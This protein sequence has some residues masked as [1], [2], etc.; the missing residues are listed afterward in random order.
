MTE[1]SKIYI[2]ALTCCLGSVYAAYLKQS[3]PVWMDTL[4]S[5][6]VVTHPS[7]R[8]TLA[9]CEPYGRLRVVTTEVF[10]AHN[11]AFNKGAAL[12]QAYAA[13]D[14]TDGVLHFDSDIMPPKNWREIAERE[15]AHGSIHGAVRTEEAGKKIE[16]LGDWP[17]G[18]FQLWHAHDVATHF[19][20]I[21][22]VWHQS[23]GGYDLEFLEKWPT[24]LRR[25][26]SF[27]VVHFGEVRRNWFGVGL[28]PEQQEESFKKMDHVHKIGLRKARLL[29]RV[30]T[31]RLRV[32]PF[33]LRFAIRPDP[34]RPERI[35]ELIRACQT[36]DPFLVEA[37]VGP[38]VGKAEVISASV[39]PHQ[40]RDRVLAAYQARHGSI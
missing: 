36:R 29:T 13:M 19:W 21:M 40:L 20:P 34:Q 5:L 6:T 39:E 2:D 23:A 10:K 30:P 11:A 1:G 9:V 18:Y 15:F 37:W 14:P 24:K 25:K 33:A 28:P 35:H 12:T 32:P 8:D 4:D 26:L 7:D 17:Y 16:D 3:L 38:K 27:E 31:N 22:E